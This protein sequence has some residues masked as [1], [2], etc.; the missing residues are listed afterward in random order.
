MGH[1]W[2][3]VLQMGARAN[4]TTPFSVVQCQEAGTGP[5]PDGD[6]SSQQDPNK[7]CGP[8]GDVPVGGPPA[9]LG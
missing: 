8:D 5:W 6:A 7:R 1:L 2:H 4:V 9:A 3:Q